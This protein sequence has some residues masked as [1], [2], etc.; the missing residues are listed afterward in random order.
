[1]QKPKVGDYYKLYPRDGLKPFNIIQVTRIE[2]NIA[3]YTSIFNAYEERW[4]FERWTEI[5]NYKLT[6]L[7]IE[8]L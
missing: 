2:D 8:L 5:L 4:D 6:P 1:M 3:F 7:E